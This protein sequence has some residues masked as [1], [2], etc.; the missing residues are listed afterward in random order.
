MQAEAQPCLWQQVLRA[1]S[2][3]DFVAS[4]SSV[5]YGMHEA[6][7]AYCLFLRRILAEFAF[8]I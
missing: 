6:Q 7:A 4:T 8:G 5:S 1:T 2:A 3:G